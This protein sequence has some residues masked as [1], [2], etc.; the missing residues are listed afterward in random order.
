MINGTSMDLVGRKMFLCDF[1]GAFKV[2]SARAFHENH[3]ACVQ[4]LN[5]PP[6]GRNSIG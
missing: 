4:I 3:I 1:N 6:A 2:H 5:E